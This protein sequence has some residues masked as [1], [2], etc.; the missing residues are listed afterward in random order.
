M[1]L[2]KD[3]TVINLLPIDGGSEPAKL[4]KRT[5]VKNTPR[6]GSEFYLEEVIS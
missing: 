3:V 4:T 6:R 1:T 2:P 5:A